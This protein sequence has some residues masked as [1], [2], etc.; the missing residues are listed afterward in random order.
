M[1]VRE[2]VED[3]LKGSPALSPE[4]RQYVDGVVNALQARESEAVG[5]LI[6]YAVDQGLG[7]EDAARAIGNC[8]LEVGT[9]A[10]AED[11]RIA[12]MEAQIIDMQA[13]LRALRGQ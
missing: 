4:Y 5:A 7:R 13:S 8:G 3:A 10:P 12:S 1:N 9:T 11:P 2:T 6:D